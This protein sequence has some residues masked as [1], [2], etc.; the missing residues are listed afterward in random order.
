MSFG[1]GVALGRFGANGE[2]IL[3]EAP[4]SALPG[5]IL[6][7][8]PEGRDSLEHPAC[9]LLHEAWKEHG[10]KVGGGDD[11]G[12]YLRTSFFAYHKK[13][14]EN[15]PIYFPLSSAKKS[16]VAFASIHRWKDDTLNV[17]LADHLVPEKRRLEGE[18]EDI[19]KA[20]TQAAGKGKAEKRFAEFESSKN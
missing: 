10:A 6:F 2:G 13:L 7:I 20:R 12:T 8:V 14:Y 11:L 15:R 17:L 5:G 16:Y 4:D 1:I 18:L 19:R 3:D 9:S